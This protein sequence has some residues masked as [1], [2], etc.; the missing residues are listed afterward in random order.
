[1]SYYINTTQVPN[2]LMDDLLKILSSS[3][4]KVLL[5]IIRKTIGMMHPTIKNERLDKAWISQKLFMVCTSL[6][7]RAVSSAI[8]SLVTKDLIQ[9]LDRNDNLL[10]S[11]EKRRRSHRLYF[12]SRLRLVPN[13]KQTSELIC[14]NTV[15]TGHTIKLNNETKSCYNKSQGIKRLSDTERYQQIQNT[16]NTSKQ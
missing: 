12:A 2:I 4:L 14:T 16:L 15:N 9:V 6:S 3:E 13:P 1:M 5:T 10:L 7:G 11:K 8:D